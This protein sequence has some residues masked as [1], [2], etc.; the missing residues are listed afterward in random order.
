VNDY[1][2][3]F[4]LLIALIV[5]FY[6]GNNVNL[7]FHAVAELLCIIIA[8]T[9][10][11]IAFSTYNINVDNRILSISLAYGFASC[12]NLIH[13]LSYE[14]IEI[15]SHT[16]TTNISIQA[17]V[18][19]RY[20]ESI[21]LLIV[22]VFSKVEFNFKKAFMTYFIVSILIFLAIFKLNVFPVCYIEGVGL[23]RFKI[24][25]GY[26]NFGI[27]ILSIILIVKN[28]DKKLN[29]NTK[30][31]LISLI[32]AII[33]DMLLILYRDLYDLVNFA[34]HITKLIS[35]Y[36]IYIAL[37]E[38][39]IMRPQ[40][41]MKEKYK[42]LNCKNIALNKKYK[43]LNDKNMYLNKKIIS[44]NRNNKELIKQIDDLLLE[45]DKNQN[46]EKEIIDKGEVLDMILEDLGEGI[47]VLSSSGKVL[48][49]NNRFLNM[50]NISNEDIAIKDEIEIYNDIK[51]QV[52]NLEESLKLLEKVWQTKE[53]C[54]F[55]V[56]VKDNRVFK[57]DSSLFIENEII[58]GRIFSIKDITEWKRED[59][60]QK[61]LEI[62]QI[63]KNEE[64]KCD[65]I[66]NSFFSTISHEFRTPLN[67]IL[68]SI[69]LITK[70]NDSN[71]DCYNS[72]MFTKYLNI[73]KQN[74]NRLVKL[75]NNIIDINN[76]ESG[77]IQLNLK[78]YNII[79][80][81]ENITMETVKYAEMKGISLVF[82]TDVE[83]KIIACDA[84]K[85]EK[86]VLNL[87][88]NAIKYTEI[89][90]KIE[91]FVKEHKEKIVLSVKDTGI[92]I[93]SSMQNQIFEKFGQ[94]DTSFT[95][96][97][98]GSGIG[99]ALVKELVELHNGRISLNSKVG[100]GSEFIVELPINIG[101]H[102]QYEDII[103]DRRIITEK[104]DI[105]FSDIYF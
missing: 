16:I 42:R 29:R 11:I 44:L 64:S 87:L 91:V 13:V 88:S 45:I 96:Q 14:G 37:I 40:I 101:D 22:L 2:K 84:D 59:E 21:A 100:R 41:Y 49:H 3:L 90:G 5:V 17:A 68:G 23:T 24:V 43:K 34:G 99:L 19:A 57:V 89:N 95:R 10:I 46:S 98:E 97:K 81:V 20:I 94:V 31:I 85:I 51:K 105:E 76:I 12:F 93:P 9:L 39:S 69:Q 15:L 18:A 77:F 79:S 65:E 67:M 102:K 73:T 27:R 61:K 66:K 71:A 70:I 62:Q 92:G 48:Y 33:T 56:E 60:L 4:F 74:C 47:L 35:I 36:L 83:E 7:M 78:N 72:N 53:K 103:D 58:L 55:V 63:K 52:S 82:D 38:S 86:I 80:I 25:S 1:S 50:W 28:K 32:A 75:V 8:C 104:I 26:V 30:L 54:S 6:D